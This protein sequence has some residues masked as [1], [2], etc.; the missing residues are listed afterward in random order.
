MADPRI[1]TTAA[2]VAVA[3]EGEEDHRGGTVDGEAEGVLPFQ[4]TFDVVTGV[5][6]QVGKFITSPFVVDLF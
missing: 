3:G 6:S 4:N 2:A 1:P 5:T